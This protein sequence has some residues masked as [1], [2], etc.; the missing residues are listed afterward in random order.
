VNPTITIFIF[1]F[2]FQVGF[3]TRPVAEVPFI[4]W[5]M[6][7]MV[8]WFF[9]ADGLSS[10]TTSITEK[11]YLVQ[12]VV[13][14]VS[15]LPIV[16]ILSALVIHVFFL[17]VLFFMFLGYGF[18]PVVHSVQV[19]YYLFA[20]IVL[21]LGLS[22]ITSSVIIFLRDTGNI[23]SMILQFGFWMTPV[24]WSLNILP[25]KYQGYIKLNPAYYIVEGYRDSFINRVWFWEHARL[26]LYYWS[27]TG[28]IFV[29][30]AIVFRKLRPHFAD[31]L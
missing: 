2:V 23:V 9:I 24:F 17:V 25:E 10:A 21:L 19:I 18:T 30:G 1:W 15:T 14:R 27:V 13:F 26:T 8:P 29:L 11:N 16:K 4:L 7:G 31:V 3:K 6:A 28:T 12:K 20:M 5:L 22:W